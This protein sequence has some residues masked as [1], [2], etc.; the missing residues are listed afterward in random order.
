MFHG[1]SRTSANGSSCMFDSLVG[2]LE[3]IPANNSSRLKSRQVLF[4]LVPSKILLQKADSFDLPFRCV[5]KTF[6]SAMG[7]SK[8][9]LPFR[10]VLQAFWFALRARPVLRAPFAGWNQES[11]PDTRQKS[12]RV[13]RRPPF[14]LSS[15]AQSNSSRS[16]PERFPSFGVPE[17]T[18]WS[19][20]SERV[21]FAVWRRKENRQGR[22]QQRLLAGAESSD[23]R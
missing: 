3:L 2:F 9:G 1:G 4:D 23:L 22:F 8:L 12:N 15:L 18:N 5:L 20:G 11:Q 6:W 21:V 14:F 17:N 10:C 16:G 13:P 7:A 19:P